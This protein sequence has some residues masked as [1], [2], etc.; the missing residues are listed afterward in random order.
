MQHCIELPLSMEKL[1][2][3]IDSPLLKA[4]AEGLLRSPLS[5]RIT[6]YNTFPS[7]TS[8]K[9]CGLPAGDGIRPVLAPGT[10]VGFIAHQ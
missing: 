5:L 4:G 8:G 2:F 3:S 7:R 9:S 10:G 6:L 1:C